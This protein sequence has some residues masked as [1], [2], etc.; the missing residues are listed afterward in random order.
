MH[1]HNDENKPV[2]VAFNVTNQRVEHYVD[3]IDY[4]VK[5][6]INR[7]KSQEQF[8]PSDSQIAFL[9]KELVRALVI[10][11][12]VDGANK[13]RIQKRNILNEAN[14]CLHTWT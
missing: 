10:R 8:T 12:D 5:A 4:M 9:K 13:L 7:C 3:V 2:R 14:N 11:R 6:E 1:I